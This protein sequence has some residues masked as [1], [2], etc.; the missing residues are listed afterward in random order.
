MDNC[1]STGR[2]EAVVIGGSTGG[3]RALLDILGGLP[4][5]CGLP[6]ICV[7]HRPAVDDLNLVECMAHRLALQVREVEERD[8]ARPGTVY[9][10]PANYHVLIE[11]DCRFSLSVDEP[12]YFCRPSIDVLFESAAAV[13]GRRLLAIILTGANPDGAN[14]VTAV[15]EHGGVVAVQDPACAEAAEMPAAA[16]ASGCVNYIFSL[17]EL[18]EFLAGPAINRLAPRS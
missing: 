9:V 3:L 2:F 14:G 6:F 12:V 5:D 10:A 11:E 18:R 16:L 15:R 7:L 8:R 1:A 13:Y 4:A 17:R